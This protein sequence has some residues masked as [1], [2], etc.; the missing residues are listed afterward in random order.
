MF[1]VASLEPVAFL[2][3]ARDW[4][5]LASC[6]AK[7]CS[8]RRLGIVGPWAPPALRVPLAVGRGATVSAMALTASPLGPDSAAMAALAPVAWLAALR[9]PATTRFWLRWV[10][11]AFCPR[12]IAVLT[13]LPVPGAGLAARAAVR[14]WRI[15]WALP[16]RADLLWLSCWNRLASD[17]CVL[18]LDPLPL[19]PP[20]DVV[21]LAGVA[22]FLRPV[23]PV[24]LPTPARVPWFIPA[25][26]RLGLRASEEVVWAVETRARAGRPLSV[27]TGF[28]V[29]RL[30]R[31]LALV[32]F[33]I[34][35][36]F[37]YSTEATV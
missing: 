9:R 33:A 18:G 5:A 35:I 28:F 37:L 11:L 24:T 1:G 13:T 3:A 36:T 19:S 10:S 15:Y 22:G 20:R 2:R 12:S 17:D 8:L 21:T 29:F 27:D 25:R 7:P 16:S 30:E 6:F 14:R 4:R 26:T 31:L 23:V 32:T 34:T